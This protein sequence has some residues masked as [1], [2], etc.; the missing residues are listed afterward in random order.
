M[1]RTNSFSIF[2]LRELTA[3]TAAGQLDDPVTGKTCRKK[4]SSNGSPTPSINAKDQ[5]VR[6]K[7]AVYNQ[8][9]E[10]AKSLAQQDEKNR[11]FEA[12]QREED[13][14]WNRNELLLRKRNSSRTAKIS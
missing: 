6:Q 12:Q 5:R 10:C 13:H 4:K 14:K 1:R 8:L 3:C 11:E 9:E 2:C 7:E